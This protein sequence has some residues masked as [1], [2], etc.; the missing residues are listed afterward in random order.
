MKSVTRAAELERVLLSHKIE[1][2]AIHAGMSQD[3]RLE[4]Y[5]RFKE[6]KSSLLIATDIFSRG[7][8]IGKVNVVIN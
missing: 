8:D 1:C 4:R 7:L 6:N 2:V 5:T 3:K